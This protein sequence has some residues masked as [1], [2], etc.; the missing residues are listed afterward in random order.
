MTW[1]AVGTETKGRWLNP[2]ALALGVFAVALFC[3]AFLL[4]FVQP[5]FA[6]MVLPRLG[7]SPGVWSIAMVVFQAL[8]L[9]GYAYAHGLTTRLS[10]R[11]SAFVHLAL[12]AVTFVALP[13]GI[14]SVLGEAP[15]ESPAAW[16]IGIFVLSI[17]LPFF[18]LA[19]NGPLLQAWFSRT[20]HPQA[21]DP[22]FLYGASNLGSFAGLILYPVLFEPALSLNDQSALWTAGFATLFVL[23]ALAALTARGGTNGATSA[24]TSVTAEPAPTARQALG[25]VALSFLP[26]GLLVAVTA[27]V[28]TDV[29]A[30]PFLWVVPLA[31]YLLTF[32]L[33]FRARPLVPMRIVGLLFLAAAPLLVVV[34]LLAVQLSWA[35]LVLP[36]GF[37][38]LA[39]LVCHD[40][41]Y[42]LR[43]DARHLTH[44]YLWMSVGGVLGGLF[45]GL[46]A[47]LVFDTVL[48]FPLLAVL[49]VAAVPAVSAAG[50]ARFAR[51]VLP[52]LAVGAIGIAAIALAPEGEL[53]TFVI[54]YTLCVI[55]V[56]TMVMLRHGLVVFASVAVLF[57]A[58]QVWSR[59]T[60][61]QTFERSLFGVHKVG[62]VQGG[63][64]RALS[65][66]TTLHGLIRIRD[67]DGRPMTG[68][69]IPLTYYHPDGPIADT[70]RAVPGAADGR[71][72]ALI[73]LGTGSHACNGTDADRWTIYEIDPLVVRIARDAARF[74]FLSACAPTAR[75][76]L[77][78]AR[79]TLSHA[80]GAA[81]DYLLVDAFSSDSIPVHLLT[82]EAV[83]LYMKRLRPGGLLALHIS[84]RNMELASVV[85]AIAKDLGLAA[86]I[87]RDHPAGAANNPDGRTA[88]VVVALARD[89]AT[90]APLD[91]A[92]DWTP[93][94]PTGTAA[95][96]DDYS[97]LVAAI[98]RKYRS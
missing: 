60:G 63:D 10:T 85:A 78:D 39:A 49:S 53:R 38:V 41:L 44:F 8:L 74:R 15:P 67:R 46:I 94:A 33:V 92:A 83:A 96:T 89:P 50:P 2:E 81:Y 47:P 52:I 11:A 31:L 69:P 95:W 82:R 20:G 36:I 77:G 70:L 37:F 32:S 98:W 7:G 72:L 65:H 79:L 61:A 25:W 80:P 4:F 93:L 27:H 43:P 55:G 6:K 75:I 45:A 90:L 9:A 40:R 57:T 14:T 76:V 86:R 3:S 22:Y 88:S 97:N 58:T 12:M 66:G 21:N 73:G 71:D 17:G 51:T 84:N 1:T 23:V 28:S 34:D 13:I 18:A 59:G 24:A 48:E 62:L 30:A 35:P 5:M 42:R 64:F 29:A 19:G 91:A 68:R 54:P 56:A 87:R 16:L 26:S